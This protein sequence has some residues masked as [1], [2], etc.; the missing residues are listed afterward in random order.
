MLFMLMLIEDVKIF[1]VPLFLTEIES[2]E[3]NSIIIP[4]SDINSFVFSFSFSD[5]VCEY[6]ERTINNMMHEITIIEIIIIFIAAE[7]F[8]L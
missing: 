3:A 5:A 1:E 8:I 2:R 4:E 6:A 7:A